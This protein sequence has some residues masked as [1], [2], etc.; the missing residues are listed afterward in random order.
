MNCDKSTV[1][2]TPLADPVPGLTCDGCATTHSGAPAIEA[3]ERAF[4]HINSPSSLNAV[5]GF[6]HPGLTTRSK[7][8]TRGS[9][10]RY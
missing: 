3:A 7:D 5:A 4:C 8:A 2:E 10:H 1:R 9:W 6:A